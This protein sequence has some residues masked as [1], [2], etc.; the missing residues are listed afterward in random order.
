VNALVRIC[1]GGDQQWSSLPRQWTL[2]G[3]GFV[4]APR[5]NSYRYSLISFWQVRSFVRVSREH[6]SPIAAKSED[7]PAIGAESEVRS[8]SRLGP[9]IEAH[10]K[11]TR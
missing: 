9:R 11:Y 3:V 8:R 2:G 7:G 1:A 4:I 10:W 6:I 5:W